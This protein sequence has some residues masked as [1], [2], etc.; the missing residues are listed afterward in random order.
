MLW[1]ISERSQDDFRTVGLGNNPY[2][3]RRFD[4]AHELELVFYRV[5][6][7]GAL[8]SITFRF[9]LGDKQERARR[10]KNIVDGIFESAQIANRSCPLNARALRETSEIG[11]TRGRGRHVAGSAV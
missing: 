7:G 9:D 5:V 6:G 2:A 10:I 1:T 4:V 8:R 11:R 3:F